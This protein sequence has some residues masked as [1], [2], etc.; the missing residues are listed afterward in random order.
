MASSNWA[1]NT[2]PMRP[3]SGTFKRSI[4]LPFA[5]EVVKAPVPFIG[6]RS[7]TCSVPNLD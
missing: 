4:E 6:E 7:T 3:N 5:R 2:L 1:R